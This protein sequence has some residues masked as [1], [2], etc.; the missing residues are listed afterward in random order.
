MGKRYVSHLFQ[1]PDLGGIWKRIDGSCTPFAQSRRMFTCLPRLYSLGAGTDLATAWLQID[2]Q[3][4]SSHGSTFCQVF[5]QSI[6][7]RNVYPS[8]PA[9]Q[10]SIKLDITREPHCQWDLL[11]ERSETNTRRWACEVAQSDS[12]SH[13]PVQEWGLGKTWGSAATLGPARIDLE[14]EPTRLPVLLNV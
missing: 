6:K 14:Y 4:W 3:D 1:R 10:I 12:D 8:S 11:F 2:I 13:S 7:Q 5:L 9:P